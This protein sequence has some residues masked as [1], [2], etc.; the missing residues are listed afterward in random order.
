MRLVT[1][2][3]VERPTWLELKTY[4]HDGFPVV[5]FR[6]QLPPLAHESP[7]QPLIAG[8]EAMLFLDMY[9]LQ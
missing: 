2:S 7:W 1:F 4:M 6:T 8:N 5:I 3:G 9:L